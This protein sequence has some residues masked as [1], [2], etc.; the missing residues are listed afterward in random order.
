VEKH[1][2]TPG[3]SLRPLRALPQQL[4]ARPPGGRLCLAWVPLLC[5]LTACEITYHPEGWKEPE[6]HGLA[7]SHG[8]DD[9][10]LCHGAELDGDFGPSC[11]G[12][13]ETGWR[14]DCA[15]CHDDPTLA[16]HSGDLFGRQPRFEHHVVHLADR[17]F[18]RALDC[19]DCHRE[20]EEV[21]SKDHVLDDTRGAV[22][23]RMEASRGGT[24]EPETGACADTWC[25]GDGR[26]SN[27][28][29]EADEVDLGC[30]SCHPDET[31]SKAAWEG[32]SPPHAAHMEED[33]SCGA[34][35]ASVIDPDGVPNDRGLHLD[36]DIDVTFAVQTMRRNGQQCSGT[37]HGQPHKRRAWRD[38]R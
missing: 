2:G 11:D 16:P 14:K 19:E 38:P 20:V 31:S 26:A 5:V 21:L 29:V 8:E 15:F 17:P 4:T 9:C 23:V 22:E 10:Q 7:F 18:S 28:R 13:H 34:C 32:M 3:A 6:T 35:H 37:C 12:C 30:H 33:L 1:Y 27:G 25:H 24:F 36:G